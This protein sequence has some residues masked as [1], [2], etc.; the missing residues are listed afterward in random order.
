MLEG[1][2]LVMQII[3]RKLDIDD[4]EKKKVLTCAFFIRTLLVLIS[5]IIFL[6]IVV[7]DEN[8]DVEIDFN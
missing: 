3:K 4:S 5:G 7:L 8:I 2:W 1:G 6:S